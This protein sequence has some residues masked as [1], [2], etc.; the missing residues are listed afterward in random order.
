[1]QIVIGWKGESGLAASLGIQS[2]QILGDILCR[3]LGSCLGS[4]PFSAAE[5]RQL[6]KTVIGM[7]ADIL[8]YHIQL[9]HGQKETVA[10]RVTNVDIVSA[11][12]V[13]RQVFNSHI[14]SDTVNLVNH[15]IS[16]LQIVIGKNGFRTTPLFLFSL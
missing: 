6:H 10:S 2:D 14:L 9:I 11:D 4:A 1:M 13:H 12:T 5:A 3:R 8:G 16:D 7:R 15:E